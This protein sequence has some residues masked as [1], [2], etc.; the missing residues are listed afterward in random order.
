MNSASRPAQD[1]FESDDHPSE[2]AITADTS[3]VERSLRAL[4]QDNAFAVLD[5][6]GDMGNESDRAEGLFYNDTRYLSKFE[7]RLE[8]RRLLLLGSAIQ[9][10]NAAL[11][12]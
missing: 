4:K 7:M 2:H 12:T 5:A 3:L 6:Y 8:G 11:K 1:R 10:D 9:D